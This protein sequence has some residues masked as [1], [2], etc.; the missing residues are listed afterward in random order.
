MFIQFPAIA[1]RNSPP[2]RP[3]PTHRWLR[4]LPFHHMHIRRRPPRHGIIRRTPHSRRHGLPHPRRMKPFIRRQ[5]RVA[6]GTAAG[7]AHASRMRDRRNP[8]PGQPVFRAAPRA[9]GDANDRHG[10][11]RHPRPNLLIQRPTAAPARKTQRP[12]RCRQNHRS[13]HRHRREP[14]VP[15]KRVSAPSL[16]P[17]ALLTSPQ[18]LNSAPFDNYAFA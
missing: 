11:P 6:F 4:P 7:H 17:P 1:L 12:H 14:L 3:T 15:R 8:R 2:S 13:E 9:A 16:P 5:I 18:A 10:P